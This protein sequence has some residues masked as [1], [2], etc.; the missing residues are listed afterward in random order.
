MFEF[1]FFVVIWIHVLKTSDG[2]LLQIDV[3]SDAASAF[4]SVVTFQVWRRWSQRR[5]ALPDP[6]EMLRC[7]RLRKPT[8]WENYERHLSAE[9]VI[10]W[11]FSMGLNAGRY[12]I[13]IYIIYTAHY[14]CCFILCRRDDKC[15]K[16]PLCVA[17][18][19]LACISRWKILCQDLKEKKDWN[20]IT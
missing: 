8:N 6:S 3:R 5:P 20:V 2:K 7:P 12:S 19:I 11:W 1:I 10:V 14:I 16:Q 18:W 15:S 13:C 17:I 9:S 4:C